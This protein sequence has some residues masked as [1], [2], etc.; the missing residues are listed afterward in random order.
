MSGFFAVILLFLLLLVLMGLL[1]AS[2]KGPRAVYLTA[3][4]A[5]GAAWFIGLLL[6]ANLDFHP[7][8]F[9]ALRVLLPVLAMGLCILRAILNGRP[10]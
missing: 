9:L 3:V 2:A 7:E 8:G 10:D 5:T 1:I 6:D 4:T